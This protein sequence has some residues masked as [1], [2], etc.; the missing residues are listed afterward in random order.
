MS[1]NVRGK[2]N[3]FNRLNMVE[4]QPRQQPGVI[5]LKYMN[6]SLNK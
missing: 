1:V 6:S 4:K 5:Y 2:E 3:N